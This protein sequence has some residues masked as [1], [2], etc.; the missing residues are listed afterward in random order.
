MEHYLAITYLKNRGSGCPHC[1]GAIEGHSMTF[2]SGEIC[3]RI[4]CT[5][6]QEEWNDVYKLAA[7]TTT[8]GVLIASVDVLAEGRS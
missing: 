5:D 8:N 6:C 4:S 1:G 3:Q 2:E 7:I